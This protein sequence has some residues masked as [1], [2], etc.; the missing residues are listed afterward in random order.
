LP[1]Q[2]EQDDNLCDVRWRGLGELL[3]YAVKNCRSID[4]A[5]G[6]LS[7]NLIYDGVG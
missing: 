3:V 2:S 6:S 7:A 1:A 5:R 4:E